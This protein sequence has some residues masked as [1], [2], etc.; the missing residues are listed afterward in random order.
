[1]MTAPLQFSQFLNQNSPGI[2]GEG[3]VASPS[4]LSS[5][6]WSAG[7]DPSMLAIYGWRRERDRLAL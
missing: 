7:C 6:P 3:D 5:V 1:M 2:F 4:I